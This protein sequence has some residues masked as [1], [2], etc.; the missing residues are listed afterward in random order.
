[1]S[2]IHGKPLDA[3]NNGFISELSPDGTVKNLNFVAGS[4]KVKLNAPKGMALSKGVL[5]VSD[6]DR[7]RMF[8][9]KSGAPRGEV[10]IAGSSFLNDVAAGPDGKVYVS[11]SGLAQG[12][13]DFEPTGTDAV[14][15]IEKGKAKPLAKAKELNR[16]NGLLVDDKG[17]MVCTFGAAEVFR[18]G[19]K[20]EK[21]EVTATP[22][23][24]LDGLAQVE[25]GI[26][27]S[28]WKGEAIYKGTL[29]GKFEPI[30]EGIGAPADIA[31]DK[32]RSRVVVPRFMADTVEAYTVK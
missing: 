5:Y 21:T 32:K 4:D 30:L 7:V 15:V 22:N 1:M 31:Y 24:G 13:S 3:D 2:N 8:D 16:P 27:V 26:L 25:G 10:V 20:G 18:L 19:P 29:G 6:I 14:Y 12:K 28:S 23:P 11:D 9:A 17:V